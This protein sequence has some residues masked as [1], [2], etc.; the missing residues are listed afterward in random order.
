MFKQILSEGARSA[1]KK[2]ITTLI[3]FYKTVEEK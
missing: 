2:E 1:E 3:L